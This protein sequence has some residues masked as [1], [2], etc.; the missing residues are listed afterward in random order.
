[1]TL[2]RNAADGVSY[3]RLSPYMRFD[4][5]TGQMQE[6]LDELSPTVRTAGVITSLHL[7]LFAAPVLRW[8]YFLVSLAG[9]GM[10][11]TGLVLWIAKRRQKAG[12]RAREPSRC[13]WWMAN[14]GTV[15]GL[16][17]AVA[18][19]FW[20]N[21]LLPPDLRDASS[22]KCAL[23]SAWGLSLVYAFLFQRR[24]WLDLLARR[25]RVAG[26]GA[27]DQCVDHPAPSG[28]LAAG[29]RLGDGRIRPDLPGR[30]VAA[31]LDGPQGGPRPQGASRP[32]GGPARRPQS[33]P[34]A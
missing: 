2:T 22:G 26:A 9:T 17:I 23:F 18:A 16:F 30:C 11:G 12:R 7:G 5:V 27:G 25:R 15:A 8:F 6:N 1:M 21:R 28:G 13:A 14:A 34:A 10:V 20:A 31:G 3:G 24:K 4:G 32:S 29:R 19:F 33:S